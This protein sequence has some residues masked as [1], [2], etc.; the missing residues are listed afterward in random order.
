MKD[1]SPIKQTCP[2]IDRV[3]SDIKDAYGEMEMALRYIKGEDYS[4]A[5]SSIES[6]MRW[7]EDYKGK[8][9]NLLED[10]RNANSNLREWG[11]EQYERAENL[12]KELS[13]K[14]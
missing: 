9:F 6:A 1:H 11:N 13:T 14:E 2:D 12:E 8:R 4:G 5:E 7:I 10:I 3:I